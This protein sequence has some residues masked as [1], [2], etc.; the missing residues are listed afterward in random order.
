MLQG[1]GRLPM[2]KFCDIS[3]EVMRVRLLQEEG[4]VPLNALLARL[5]LTREVARLN[6]LGSVP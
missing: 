6:K 5:R 2:R 4:R 1:E 3:I